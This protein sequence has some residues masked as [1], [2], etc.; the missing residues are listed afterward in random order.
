MMTPKEIADEYAAILADEPIAARV[1]RRLAGERTAKADAEYAA[2]RAKYWPN[3][4][5]DYTGDEH[6]NA[7]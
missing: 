5:P 2:L 4:F 3:G 6:G 7:N 1:E